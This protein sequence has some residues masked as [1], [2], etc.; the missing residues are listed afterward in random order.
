MYNFRLKIEKLSGNPVNS[1]CECPAG[2]DPIAT[3]KHIAAV[4]LMIGV[5][6]PYR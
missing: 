1:N 5:I 2:K 4:L 6:F 3:Y